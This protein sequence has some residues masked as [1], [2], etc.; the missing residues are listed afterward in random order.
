[1]KLESYNLEEYSGMF[2]GKQQFLQQDTLTP[3]S[4]QCCPGAGVL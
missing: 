3:A 4:G 2:G 1:M